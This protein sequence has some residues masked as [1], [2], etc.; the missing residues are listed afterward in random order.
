MLHTPLKIWRSWMLNQTNHTRKSH[1]SCGQWVCS[2]PRTQRDLNAIFH[3]F[4][5]CNFLYFLNV[6]TVIDFYFYRVHNKGLME[7]PR[8]SWSVFK[9]QRV[10][11]RA[12]VQPESFLGT[13][14]PTN[15]W[16]ATAWFRKGTRGGWK[17]EREIPDRKRPKWSLSNLVQMT[18][19]THHDRGMFTC[20][21]LICSWPMSLNGSWLHSVLSSIF[22]KSTRVYWKKNGI[23]TILQ[24]VC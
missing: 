23:H 5:F 3:S 18:D 6:W 9:R 7:A 13:I 1:S 22:Q 8:H 20:L 2:P 15:R 24:P 21:S 16:G 11:W 17:C 12:G 4:S 10:N 14:E 19:W